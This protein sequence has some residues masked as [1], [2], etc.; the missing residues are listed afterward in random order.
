MRPRD[1]WTN[2]E[3]RIS[4][5]SVFDEVKIGHREVVHKVEKLSDRQ[6]RVETTLQ[7]LEPKIITA[8]KDSLRAWESVLSLKSQWKILLTLA[9]GII[10]GATVLVVR[11]FIGV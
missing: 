11:S 3:I 10:I 4:L 1:E 2:P 5:D 8:A 7:H 6:I 9:T